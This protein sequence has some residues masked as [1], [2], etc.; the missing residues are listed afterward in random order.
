MNK[1]FYTP[2]ID[3]AVERYGLSS[4]SRQD[5]YFKYKEI[6]EIL[7]KL[8]ESLQ[9]IKPRMDNRDKVWPFW[10]CSNR[11]SM[12]AF[13]DDEE[14]ED[15]K[16]SG[17]IQSRRDLESLRNDYYPEEIN[18]HKVFFQIYDEIFF[19][20]FGSKVIFQLN[21]K[22]KQIAGTSYKG[23]QLVEFLLWVQFK[24]E[25]EISKALKDIDAYNDYIA[26]NLSLCKRFG[27]IKRIQIWENVPSIERLDEELGQA[28]LRRFEAAVNKMDKEALIGA[29][30][31][32]K[33]FQYC[34]LCYDSNDYFK[35]NQTRT[36]R[37]K[38]RKM[39]DGRDEGLVD[40]SGGSEKA[41]ENWY[42]DKSHRG[43]H[44]WEICRGGN[45]TH[46]SLMVHKKK[47][48]WQ[49]YLAGS[50]SSRVLETAM[51]AI[52][53]SENDVPFILVDSKKLLS[54]LKGVDYCGIVPKDVTPKYCHN[55]FPREDKIIDFI[56]PWHDEELV[57][58]IKKYATW[59]PLDRLELA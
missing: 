36:P 11:G 3:Q 58:V 4:F 8:L 9:I 5:H 45:S 47:E 43:G 46:I 19:F 13:M 30:A 7:V 56:N 40:I 15:M 54:M 33:F 24:I 55:C 25:N 53:L 44:P 29:M 35:N 31:A 6:S 32:D 1:E 51:M 17:E 34:Q 10:I 37:A 38:Y 39:A 52:A 42:C 59:Y 18:W 57:E 50:S 28:N 26:E 2:E 27:R 16:E 49:L 20:G 14:Y 12:S 41:F 22:T 48:G 23:K 21:I